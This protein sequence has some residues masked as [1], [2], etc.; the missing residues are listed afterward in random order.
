LHIV[1]LTGW[2]IEYLNC[3][4]IL[5]LPGLEISTTVCP[6]FITNNAVVSSRLL[7]KCS[8]LFQSSNKNFQV[9]VSLN[10][11]HPKC[12]G[13]ITTFIIHKDIQVD[14]SISRM[15]QGLVEDVNKYQMDETDAL[16]FFSQTVSSL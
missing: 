15:A 16:Q 9:K 6:M 4:K 2:T 7:N 3:L 14:H 5:T 12:Q 1:D 13:R 11:L 10:H 8:G